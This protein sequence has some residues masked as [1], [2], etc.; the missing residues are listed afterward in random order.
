MNKEAI[1]SERLPKAVGPY[2]HANTAGEL[3]FISGQLGINPENGVMA[4]DVLGQAKQGLENLKNILEDT[5]SSLNNVVKTTVFLTD[6]AD[7]AEVNKIYAEYFTQSF[8]A[9]SCVAVAALPMNGKFEIE[10]VA[11]K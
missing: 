9:R 7:F 5:G 11:V 1:N 3:V 6:M 10:A 8:P 2:S 4:E